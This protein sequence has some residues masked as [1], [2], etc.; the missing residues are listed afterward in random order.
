MDRRDFLK[1]GAAM[2]CTAAFGV[3]A[4]EAGDVAIPKRKLGSTGEMLSIVGLGGIVLCGNDQPASDRIVAKAHD[5]GVNYFD[6]A[7]SYGNG[8]AEARLGPALKPYRSSSFLACKTAR[9]DKAGAAEELK[10]SL[11][12]LQTDHFDL[13]QLHGLPSVDE[14]KTALGPGGAIEAFAEARKQG[15]VRFLGFSAH[16]VEAALLAMESFAFDTILFPINW[17]CWLKGDFGARVVENAH[18]KGMGILALKALARTAW[19]EGVKR[20]YPKC[21]YQPVSDP[22]LAA[23]ALRFTLSEP[24]TAAV[25]PGDERL[26]DLAM[27]AAASFK[28]LTGEERKE[29]ETAAADLEPIFRHST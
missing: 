19:P 25:P 1:L 8:E 3:G 22:D 4:V 9:R 14:V 15:L 21:W 29:L 20:D 2:G 5:R 26:F 17:V 16:S 10:A 18:A 28:P 24:V 13:Y 23:L 6:V 11:K 27:S 12:A 7:P